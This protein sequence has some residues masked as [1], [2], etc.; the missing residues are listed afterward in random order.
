MESYSHIE[1]TP[2][3]V[4]DALRA[5][6]KAKH[7]KIE[8]ERYWDEIRKPVEPVKFTYEQIKNIAWVKLKELCGDD[9]QANEY[10]I[11]I[12]RLLCQYFSGDPEFEKS[13][14]YSLSKGIFLV[15]PIGCGKTTIMK[16]FVSNHHNPF[17][18][19]SVRKVSEDYSANGHEGVIHYQKALSSIWAK[20]F[21][22]DTIGY[23]FDDLGT[24]GNKKHFGN[25]LNVMTDVIL[26]RYDSRLLRGMTH[27]TGNITG[28]EIGEIYGERVRSRLREMCNFIT[29]DPRSL[30]FRK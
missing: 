25:E 7:H 20:K 16:S 29:F 1:L 30:D 27:F 15:G 9:Y 12:V 19:V 10:N 24:E 18:M 5:V 4:E 2:E 13:G 6:R 8:S 22:H 23:C 11:P 28:D 21:G 17:A 26:A 3:E 14:E